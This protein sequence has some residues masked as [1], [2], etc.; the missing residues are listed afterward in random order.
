MSAAA[1]VLR[2]PRAPTVLGAQRWTATLAAV[3]A[4]IGAAISGDLAAPLIGLFVLSVLGGAR[5]GARIAHR[6][7]WLWTVLLA[8]ALIALT[9]Q[10][11]AGSADI[12][13]SAVRFVVLLIV[14][15]LWNRATVRDEIVLL[16]LSLLLLCGGAALT[17]E[18]IFGLSFTCYAVSATWALAL[19]HLRGE[20]EGGRSADGSQAML[21]SRRLATPRLF[22]ALAA[23]AVAGLAGSALVFFAF[24]RVTLGGFHRAGK[25]RSIAGLSNR[26]DLGGGGLIGDDPRVVLRVHLTAPV[27]NDLDYHFRAYAL[28]VWTGRGWQQRPSL[29]VPTGTLPPPPQKT[30]LLQH[31]TIEVLAGFSEGV[32]FTPPG[33]PVA[34]NFPRPPATATVPP[35]LYRNAAGDLS[36]GPVDGGVFTYGVLFAPAAPAVAALRGKGQDYPEEILRSLAVPGRLDPRLGKLTEGLIKGLDPADAAEKIEGYLR[37]NFRYTRELTQGG[38]DPVADFLFQRREGHCELFASAMVLMLRSA[39]IPARAVTGYYG[40]KWSGAGYHAVRAGDA[41]SWVEVYFPG[42]GFAAFDPTPAS[43]RGSKQDG[44]W[45]RAILVWDSI[46]AR[47][48]SNVVDYDLLKQGRMLKSLIASFQEASSRLAGKPGSSSSWKL[49]RSW[50]GAA[51]LVAAALLGI[52]LRRR[53]SRRSVRKLRADERRAIELWRQ[54]RGKLQR[55]GVA[56]NESTTPRDALE[57]SGRLGAEAQAAAAQLI[58]RY[59]EARWGGGTLNAAEAR[60]LLGNLTRQL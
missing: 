3:T 25:G 15:R 30:R 50:I 57:R 53:G 58:N 17:A 49:P 40:G 21:A 52:W 16:L 14:H 59:L 11:L 45:A 51:A 33:W 12:V 32:I 37:S 39:G 28:E 47:W 1:A 4:F 43:E 24:P 6:F 56:V 35:R 60:A 23:L 26:I 36:Y 42:V 41:H 44:L 20:I 29:A 38:P 8:G 55:A 10:V 54:A 9:S 5:W 27:E 31:A 48:R 22:G 13:L 7:A 2:A 18:L 19:L 34:I 46:E